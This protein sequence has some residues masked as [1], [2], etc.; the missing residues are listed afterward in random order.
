M[1]DL[2]G[3]CAIVTGSTR[4]IGLAIAQA[5]IAL[6]AQVVI[7]SEARP[8]RP[9]L[10]PI[11]HAGM[12]CDV[13][14]ARPLAAVPSALA[15]C[16]RLDILVCNA[17]ITGRPG[18]FADLADYARS[19]RSTCAARS[20]SATLALPHIAA[21]P[22]GAG[23]VLVASLAG[24]RGNGRINACPGRGGGGAWRATW[25]WNGPRG[26]RVNAV[27]PGFVA[28]ELSQPLLD[29]DFMAR[30]MAM[31]PLLVPLPRSRARLPSL[32]ARCRVRHRPQSRAD[33]GT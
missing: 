26:V 7:S 10:L 6:G 23:A 4:G 32:P 29:A 3:K 24:L 12:A 31:T 22:G 2:S 20:C 19:W 15:R 21:A 16:G 33:G 14:D 1:F 9:A 25:R 27:S 30:R 28:T 8:T 18:T 17:G 5:L 13:T 11:W